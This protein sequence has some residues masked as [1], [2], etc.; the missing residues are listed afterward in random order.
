M[1]KKY[2]GLWVYMIFIVLCL[3]FGIVIGF[4]YHGMTIEKTMG[5]SFNCN[6]YTTID[7]HR[8]NCNANIT[9]PSQNITMNINSDFDEIKIIAN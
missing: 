7:T 8:N 5:I 9:I 4:I 3:I 6:R 2:N 1:N